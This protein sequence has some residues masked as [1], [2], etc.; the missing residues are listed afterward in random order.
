MLWLLYNKHKQQQTSCNIEINLFILRETEREK[1]YFQ[2]LI[3]LRVGYLLKQLNSQLTEQILWSWCQQDEVKQ[4]CCLQRRAHQLGQSWQR[5]GV[6]QPQSSL[7]RWCS[8]RAV[9][10][11]MASTMLCFPKTIINSTTLQIK[12]L[13]YLLNLFLYFTSFTRQN[14]L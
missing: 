12:Q 10:Y 6:H 3:L 14:V 8:W 4:W 9:L 7:G 1:K 11:Q 5:Q 2:T 13:K